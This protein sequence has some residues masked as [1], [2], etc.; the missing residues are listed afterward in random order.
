MDV[1]VDRTC[2]A[3]RL[4]KTPLNG[5]AESSTCNDL[6]F[7]PPFGLPPKEVRKLRRI[8]I[9]AMVSLERYYESTNVYQEVDGLKL[10]RSADGWEKLI[11]FFSPPSFFV[12]PMAEIGTCEKFGIVFWPWSGG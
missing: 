12:T 10:W 9:V 3:C 7:F 6:D 11:S 8:A 5:G 1:I 2:N 4:T